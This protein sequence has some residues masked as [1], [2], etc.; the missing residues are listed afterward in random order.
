MPPRVYVLLLR[1]GATIVAAA[2]KASLAGGAVQIAILVKNQAAI[3]RVCSIA[4]IREQVE[5]LVGVLAKGGRREKK[6]SE[7]D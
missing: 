3:R 4:G 7:R 2:G 5:R 1:D 6:N